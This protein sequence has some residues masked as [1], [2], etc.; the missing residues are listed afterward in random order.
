MIGDTV[1]P[2]APRA[3]ASLDRMGIRSILLTGDSKAVANA[4]GGRLGINQVE[5]ELLPEAKLA[6]IK[7]LV[8]DGLVVAMVGDGINDA[9]AL[10]EANVGVAMGSGTDIARETGDVLLLGND[11]ARFAE[12]LQIARWT[13]RIIWQN[14]GGTIVVDVAGIALAAAGLLNPA[15]AAFIHVASEMTFILNSARLLPRFERG[16]HA[17]QTATKAGERALAKAA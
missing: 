9:P 11:L 6:R 10:A 7:K 14:F 13:R 4:V 3:I 17:G 5:G 1:R 16:A 2:E 8:A 15:M 12:T